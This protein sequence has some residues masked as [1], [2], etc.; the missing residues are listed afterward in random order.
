MQ[1]LSNDDKEDEDKEYDDKEYDDKNMTIQKMTI[2]KKKSQYVF[3]SSCVGDQGTDQT[4]A[5]IPAL[6]ADGI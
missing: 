5:A 3:N 4:Y 6:D 1:V 2:Q